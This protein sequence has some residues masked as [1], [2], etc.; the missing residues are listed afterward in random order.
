M[1]AI[2]M[3]FLGISVYFLSCSKF[4][5]QKYGTEVRIWNFTN[6]VNFNFIVNLVKAIVAGW[7]SRPQY[8]QLL[9]SRWSLFS[10]I[11][12]GL[13]LCFDQSNAADVFL[14]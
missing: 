3:L 10:S 7:K 5:G 14:G 12:A 6:L 1:K 9:P 11:R 2:C 4:L 8:F 13:L